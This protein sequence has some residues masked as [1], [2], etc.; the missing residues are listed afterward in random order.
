MNIILSWL[1]DFAPLGDASADNVE[2]IAAALNSLGLAVESVQRVGTPIAGV[3]TARVLRTERH[4]D[5]ERVHRVWLDAGDGTERHVWCGAFNMTAGDV[6]PLATLGTVMPDGRDIQKRKILGIASEGMLCSATEL[7]ISEDHSG[8]LILP[9]GTP[10]GLPIMEA[11]GIETD[12]VFEL[13]LTRNRPD[14]WGHIGVA[15]DLA[16]WFGLPF[17]LPP[18][19]VG[20]LGPGRSAPVTIVDGD[21]CGRFVST[22]LSGVNV[23]PSAPWMQRRLSLAGMRPISNVVDV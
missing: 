19:T 4:P 18:A 22:V 23:G 3:L 16:A 9:A 15:R 1:N 7:G 13:D 14:C 8:I 6:V 2:R 21:R 5:A 11:L 10:L 20:A 12:A 17:T